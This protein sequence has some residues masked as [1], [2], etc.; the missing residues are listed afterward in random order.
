MPRREPVTTAIRHLRSEQVEY[1]PHLF[2]Y[3]SHRGA[4]GA[5]KAIGI[6]PH[7]T[8]KTI[9]MTTDANDGVLVLI[10]G[11]HEVST[12]AVARI[13]GVKT[14]TT[15][16]Q[17]DARRWTGYEFGGT[18]PFGTKTDLRCLAHI[19]IANLEIAYVNGGS[20]GFI[21]EIST[22]DLIRVLHPQLADLAM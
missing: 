8:V 17:A 21:V 14:V 16:R 5:G 20:R 12:K 10:N 19:E 11:D 6:D 2:D 1:V 18:S 4:I 9:V 15:S 22:A 3:R 13:L 7:H